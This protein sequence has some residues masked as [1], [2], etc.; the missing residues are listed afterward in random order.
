[1]TFRILPFVLALLL[2]VL[3]VAQT[4]TLKAVP[5]Q[6][7]TPGRAVEAVLE[8]DLPESFTAS[9]I[10]VLAGPGAS[11][12][13][14]QV[15]AASKEGF[16]GRVT[17]PVKLETPDTGE[18][19]LVVQIWTASDPEPLEL[20]A[21]LAPGEKPRQEG[22]AGW[23]LKNFEARNYAMI[24]LAAVLVGLLLCLTPCVYPMIPITVGYFSNQSAANRGAKL[25]LGAM[26]TLGIAITYGAVGGVFAVIGQGVGTLFTQPWFLF[27]LAALMVVLALSMFDVYEIG[28]PSFI[29]KHL[30]G[31]SGP[32]GALIMGLLM[33]FAAAPCA[34]ALVSAVAIGVADTRSVPLGVTVFTAIGLGL[35]LP[36]FAL[37]S[38]STGASRA[39]PK[40]GGWLKTVKAI[41][42]LVVLW[43]GADYLFKGL[44][45]R[46]DDA[47]TFLGWVVFYVGAALYLLFFD[48]TEPSRLVQGLK[49][50]AVLGLGLLAGIAWQSRSAALFEQ[51]VRADGGSMAT[52]IQWIPWTEAAFEEAKQSGKPIFIDAWAEWCTEC[53]VIEKKVLNTPE[54]IRALQGVVTMKIDWSTGQDAGY[55][56]STAKKFDIVGLPHLMFFKPGG[57]PVKTVNELASVEELKKLV[58]EASQ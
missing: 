6:V 29:G 22:L 1:M 38:L 43:L 7:A 9:K 16:S 24:V 55:I 33:G 52:K 3:G 41:L 13:T 15:P 47:R 35:G 8:I 20:K 36:F 31:R 5:G 48:R 27:S 44:G 54:G 25:L 39:L 14:A 58:E 21:L 18:A 46:S 51:S 53:K 56:E 17:V 19:S 37:A 40:S 4:A 49:G 10:E 11:L 28:V 2:P 57:A 32:V 45:W 30:K 42:G 12:L 23:L 34:G 50:T 26:Y